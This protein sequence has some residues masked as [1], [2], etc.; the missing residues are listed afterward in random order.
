MILLLPAL[1]G[2]GP[3]DS[4]PPPQLGEAWG[5]GEL[6]TRMPTAFLLALVADVVAKDK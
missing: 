2:V 1:P 3:H 6:G 5:E 4:P